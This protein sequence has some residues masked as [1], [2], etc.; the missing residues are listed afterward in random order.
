LTD[1]PKG[2]RPISSK[3]IFKKKLRADGSID[4]YKARLLI[5]GFYQRK[6]IDY[7]ETYSPVTKIAT[8]RALIALAA[9]Y[10]LVAH[11]RDVKTAFLNGNLE[12]EIYITQP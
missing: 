7:F 9:I 3:W 10:D 12:E 5:R 11:Q 1:L 4:N 6:E 2:C 8:I